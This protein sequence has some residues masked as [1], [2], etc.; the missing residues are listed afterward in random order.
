MIDWWNLATNLLWI[1]GLAIAL[2]VLS[3]SDW[4]ASRRKDS[5]RALALALEKPL[6]HGGLALACVGAG[7]GARTGWE[8]AAWF[9]LAAG[10]C[11]LVGVSY[12]RQKKAPP[13]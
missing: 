1:S 7:L 12:R 2:A 13:R 8:R 5:G 9:L 11:L 6:L 10:F 4:V 3:H